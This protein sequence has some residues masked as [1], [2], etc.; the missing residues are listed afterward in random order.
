VYRYVFRTRPDP[1]LEALDCP[2]ASQSAPVRTVSVGAPQALVLWN[3]KF[4]LR[5]AEHL[6]ALAEKS[7]A[8]LPEQVRFVTRRVLCR[9]PTEA[10]S[11][12]WAAYARKHGLA[13]LCRVLFNSSEFLFI[14]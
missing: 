6:A 10:E 1:M 3:N 8:D 12:A 14:D 4:T 9:P 5:H 13:N 11:G 2:D 7:S